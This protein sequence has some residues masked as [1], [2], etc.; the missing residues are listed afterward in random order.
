MQVQVVNWFY[1]LPNP[2]EF[3]NAV[4]TVK[5]TSQVVDE[6]G[7][8][9]P[10]SEVRL[11]LH[12]IVVWCPSAHGRACIFLTVSMLYS[13]LLASPGFSQVSLAGCETCNSVQLPSIIAGLDAVSD[14][15]LPFVWGM[16]TLLACASPGIHSLLQ[17]VHVSLHVTCQKV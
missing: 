10:L 1:V 8:S 17:V 5:Q 11:R 7:R 3:G 6:D 15:K 14:S 13:I 9:V 2:Y 12:I 4:A 16:P